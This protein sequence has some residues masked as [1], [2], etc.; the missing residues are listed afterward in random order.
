ML[1]K[2]FFKKHMMILFIMMLSFSG[3][4]QTVLFSDD[5]ES[6]QG[7]TLTAEFQRDTAKGLAEDPAQAHQDSTMLGTDITGAD[8][9]NDGKYEKNIGGSGYPTPPDPDYATSPS[10]DCSDAS[11]KKITIS[12]YRWLNIE[13]NSKDQAVIE[14]STDGGS[15]WT[16]LWTNPDEDIFET[17]WSEQKYTL[18]DDVLGEA[19]VKIRFGID[20]T[21]N[22]NTTYGGW[23][24]DEFVVKAYT[25][26]E[27]DNLNADNITETSAKFTWDRPADEDDYEVVYG[28]PG[29][30]PDNATPTAVS[31]GSLTVND[32]VADTKYEFYVRAV[33]DADNKSIWAGPYAFTTAPC[34]SV[35][36]I[37]WYESLE[38]A[39]L[40]LRNKDGN[41]NDWVENTTIVSQGSKSI[42]IPETSGDV[43]TFYVKCPI[44][45]SGVDKPRLVFKQ[46][47][48]TLSG[49]GQ[50]YVKIS[51]DDGATYTDLPVATYKG[52]GD[53]SKG[54]FDE[55]SYSDW[56]NATDADNSLWKEDEFD[57]SDYKADTIRLMFVYDASGYT[58][59]NTPKDAWYL[60]SIV[61]DKTPTLVWENPIIFKEADA[62]NGSISNTTS[63][64]LL[65]EDFSKSSG[66]FTEGT[67][68]VTAN[69][70]EGLSVA[71]NLVNKDS[72]VISL[73]GNA[74]NHTNWADI[75]DM[76]IEFT[77]TAFSEG[78]AK[79]VK[80][81]VDSTIAVDFLFNLV[82]TEISYNPPEGGQDSLEYIEVYNADSTTINLL[83]YTISEGVTYTFDD[84]DLDKDSYIT[85]AGNQSAVENTFGVTIAGEWTGGL[86]NGGERIV[87]SDATHQILDD[88]TF[89]DGGAWSSDPDGNGPSLVFCDMS[90]DNAFGEN[91][92]VSATETG[93]TIDGKDLLGSPNALDSACTCIEVTV[94]TEPTDT[95]VC[96]GNDA[97]FF[98][99]ATGTPNIDYQWYKGDDAISGETNDTLTFTAT[100]ASDAGN[101]KCIVTNSCGED[102]TIVVTLT[103][104][105]NT[106]INT[107]PTDKTVCE[108]DDV[109]FTVEADGSNLTYQWQ[110]DG[111]DIS[112]ETS[113]S[114]TLTNVSTDDDATKYKVIVSGD[115]GDVTSDEV[116]LTVHKNTVI[117]TQPTAQEVCDGDDFTFSVEADGSNLTYQWYKDG[118]AISGATNTSYTANAS[119]AKE[120]NYK[121]IVSGDCDDVTSDEVALTVNDKTAITTQPADDEVCEG[122]DATFSVDADGTNLTYKW[123]KDG[124]E[125]SGETNATL[126]LSNVS[127][128]D[129]GTEYKV[130]VSGDCGDDDT[131]DVAILTVNVK[132]TVTD[133]PDAVEVCEG[134]SAT[135]SVTATGTAT[136]TYQWQKDGSDISGATSSSYTI[137]ETTTDDDADYK[138]IVT[139]GCGSTESAVAH[140]T[141]NAKPTVDAGAD[142]SGSEG[143]QFDLDATV[144]GGSGSYTYE[145]TPTDSIASGAD[146]E[147]ATTVALHTTNNF[148]LSVKDSKGCTNADTTKCTITG[149]PLSVDPQANKTT[150]C[151]GESVNLTSNAGGGSGNYAYQ[152]TDDQGGSTKTD[153]NIT[154]NPDVTTTYTIKVT[155][156]NNGDNVSADITITVNPLPNVSANAD[157]GTSICDG[158]ELTLTGSGASTYTWDN[159]VTD[160]VA[161]TPNVGTVTYNVTGTDDNGCENTASI[162]VT[163]NEVPS[164]SISTNDA[165]CG[166]A[167]GSAEVTATGGTGSYTY[168]WDNDGTS[169]NDDTK[170]ATDLAQGTYHV[171][172]DD[173]NCSAT[174]TANIQE[175]GAPTV[176]L[177]ADNTSIC[178]GE[179]V[180]LTAGGADTYTWTG[181]A[182]DNTT[183]N[184]VHGTPTTTGTYK[185]EGTKDGCTGNAEITITVN[186]LPVAD[187]TYTQDGAVINFTN[188]STNA[189]SYA[190]DY[191]DNNSSTEESP[192]HRYT[193]NGDYT[194]IL[195]AT[196]S[197]GSDE[198][199]QVITI[200][201]IGT[202]IDVITQDNIRIYPNP[203]S[204]TIN[205]D[206]PLEN[207]TIQL[208]SVDGRIVKVMNSNEASTVQMSVKELANGIYN[209]VLISNQNKVVVK[210]VKK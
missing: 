82:F 116:T 12:F 75:A 44:E 210:I 134:E 135:F 26:I 70:P 56:A 171:T 106:V 141:V 34:T 204:E 125:I 155:D 121:V 17:E 59:G 180:E 153:E 144:S 118:E 182:L 207:V 108:G 129:D 86:S 2:Q 183:G 191:G 190:W 29:F 57:L 64:Y 74:N 184:I 175:D 205:I 18:P 6:D 78:N 92:K 65:D 143:T 66:T 138:C 32:L 196:N 114:L 38:N 80:N 10:F 95:S 31:S 54:Y 103:V 137:D 41:T 98:L 73:E 30:D 8:E 170:D 39:P 35:Q 165:S 193:A 25:C 63:I 62:N 11:Y 51:T 195:T 23:N 20:K 27:P 109:T 88:V 102:T 178:E 197:C 158:T 14:Y 97:A 5:F 94:T 13:A 24:I 90:L 85:V 84:V 4:S 105:K 53:Y 142:Q 99:E 203:A 163:V 107:Q 149:T 119:A 77:D 7:W 50:C 130:I 42:Y 1:M 187:F 93:V 164:L 136:L 49:K 152:W 28:V 154:V 115:C 21:D 69:V 127:A 122:D 40:K 200:S 176:T 67:D 201:G 19:D 120:G 174:A 81:Y 161:F 208:V 79:N 132:P 15:N 113:A 206:L 133:D 157:P 52:S 43:D 89:D 112:G 110:K 9:G 100:T 186:P 83:D 22:A 91:W 148:I 61:I 177:T 96:E 209:L 151:A 145:W 185:V 147:D 156:T 46:I 48:N 47:A 128:S 71:I 101:Y 150:I 36:S 87:L 37:V 104:N 160:G 131:S 33:C 188:A 168:Q 199:Q 55:D 123:Y 179:T 189:D 117:N 126:T 58:M 167:D 166:N 194:V 124:T 68:F 140:L 202:G 72:A 111:S 159:N 169:D 146:A 192:S 60:D 45:L 198:A 139:N 3:M 181:E 172:V 162:D 76:K 16:N 173:G